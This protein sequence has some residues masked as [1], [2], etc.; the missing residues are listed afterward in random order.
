MKN[1][2]KEIKSEFEKEIWE[3]KILNL[4]L[5]NKEVDI[6]SPE[7]DSKKLKGSLSPDFIKNQFPKQYDKPKA[8]YPWHQLQDVMNDLGKEGWEFKETINL[9]NY[10]FLVFI[11]RKTKQ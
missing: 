2:D 10:L 6:S 3:Y 4:N 1:T 11:R 5:E 8:R 9:S 7:I